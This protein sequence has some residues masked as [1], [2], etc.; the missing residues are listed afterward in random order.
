MTE[1]EEQRFNKRR[2]VEEAS[3]NSDSDNQTRWG[4]YEDINQVEELRQWLNTKGIRELALSNEL[5]ARYQ[6][7]SLSMNKRQQD[8]YDESE[9]TPQIP[10][11]LALESLENISLITRQKKQLNIENF[12]SNNE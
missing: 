6:D 1:K 11:N 10:L 5:T 2:K 4:Y 9:P 7:I 3:F 12:F 8:I